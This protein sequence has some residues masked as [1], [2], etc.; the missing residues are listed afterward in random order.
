MKL[1]EEETII[2]E[3]VIKGKTTFQ[4]AD[5]M[6]YSEASIKKRL[7]KIYKKFNVCN[8]IQ[9]VNKLLN[10]L[11]LLLNQVVELFPDNSAG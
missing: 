7:T 4:I 3:Y 9:L 6:D 11:D 5:A 2:I 10:G 8:K 1:T